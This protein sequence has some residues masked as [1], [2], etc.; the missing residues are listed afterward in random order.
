MIQNSNPRKRLVT[1]L[2]GD[3]RPVY[4]QKIERNS[5]CQ[6]GSGLKAKKCCGTKTKLFKPKLTDYGTEQKND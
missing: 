4:S 1:F 3:G 6:C 2:P 5:K